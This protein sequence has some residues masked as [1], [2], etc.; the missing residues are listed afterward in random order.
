MMKEAKTSRPCGPIDKRRDRRVA[1][2]GSSADRQPASRSMEL[3]ASVAR[4]ARPLRRATRRVSRPSSK[5]RGCARVKRCSARRLRRV[6]RRR[7]TSCSRAQSDRQS[8]LA[9][10]CAPEGTR[11][12]TAA[13]VQPLR[14]RNA[15]RAGRL[16]APKNLSAGRSR[17]WRPRVS[18]LANAGPITWTRRPGISAKENAF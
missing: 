6:V 9:P 17:S 3:F 1:P 15:G 8:A 11:S 10:L 4:H 16:E 5:L 2:K 7:A 13:I 12:E 18:H 14:E